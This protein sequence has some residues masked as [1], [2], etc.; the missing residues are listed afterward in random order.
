VTALILSRRTPKYIRFDVDASLL[1]SSDRPGLH[2][3][4]R[5]SPCCVN[6]SLD[7]FADTLPSR[8]VAAPRRSRSNRLSR[9]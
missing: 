7:L 9:A 8:I 2:F 6:A 5:G 1:L 4:K 3:H